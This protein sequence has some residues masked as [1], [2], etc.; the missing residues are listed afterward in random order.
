MQQFLIHTLQNNIRERVH[1]LKI[2]QELINLIK[3][4]DRES[5]VFPPMSSYHRMFVH[6]VAAFFGLDHN[7]DE[8]GNSVVVVKQEGVTR[9][10]DMRFK[11]QIKSTTLSLDEPKKS[12]LKRDT[13][14]FDDFKQPLD[15]RANSL[16]NYSDLRKCKSFEEREELYVKVRARIFNQEH[17]GEEFGESGTSSSSDPTFE[18]N[19]D[20]TESF[21][22]QAAVEKSESEE[23]NNVFNSKTRTGSLT[24]TDLSKE[25]SSSKG[26]F[27]TDLNES[28]KR[29]PIPYS[30][31]LKTQEEGNNGR[32]SHSER[33]RF[34]N[35][36]KLPKKMMKKSQ[37][38]LDAFYFQHSMPVNTLLPYP[39]DMSTGACRGYPGPFPISSYID[40]NSNPAWF[41]VPSL[42]TTGSQES[43]IPQAAYTQPYMATSAEYFASTHGKI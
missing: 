4:E 31:R 30:N 32:S 20:L 7:V 42:Q 38:S 13:A 18:D 10:P 16:S 9:I 33:Y 2:E 25:S 41:T 23:L 28:Y 12:L 36:I 6:R 37:T 26:H 29:N 5:H 1:L 34:S 17:A 14:S 3:D 27:T 15:R 24:A 43:T 39:H 35:S 21:P 11:D 8:I 22:E 19:L 40:Y